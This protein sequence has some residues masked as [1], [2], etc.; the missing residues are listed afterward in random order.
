[1]STI[2]SDKVSTV[3]KKDIQELENK[4]GEF[5]L[6][7]IPE[8]KFKHFRLTRGVYGQ[9]Q[10]GV[11]LIRIKL[12]YG[13][14]TPK[15]LVKI[16]EV[17]EKYGSS[18]LHLT[19][20]QDVQI[21]YVKLSDSPKVWAELEE[22]GV[23]LREACGNTVRNVTASPD[24]GINPDEA[25][26]VTPYAHAFTQFFLRNPI[27]QDMGRKFKVAFSSSEK[28]TSFTYIHDL[29]FIPTIQNEGGIKKKGF[30]VYLGGGLG[31]QAIPAKKI[32]DFLPVESLIP[33]S[34]AVIRVFDRH[35][36]RA[37][38]NKA[39]LKFLIKKIGHEAFL[40]LVEKEKGAVKATGTIVSSGASQV[41]LPDVSAIEL[42]EPVDAVGFEKWKQTNVFEQKQTGFYGVY[43]RVQ[44]GDIPSEKAKKLAAIV[45]K[46]AGDDIR[47][48][49]NQGLLLKYVR[50]EV[51]AN[52]YNELTALDL[53]WA[54]FDSIHDI[55]ACP[56]SDTCNLAV[57]NSTGLSVVLEELLA[58]EYADLVYE[59]EIKIKISGCMNS[60]A[61][62]MSAQIGLHGSSIKNGA[63]IAP[64]MQIVLGGGIAP[65]GAGFIAEK[66]IKVPTKKVPDALR[67]I[68]NN[69]EDNKNDEE[70]FIDYVQRQGKRYFY[71]E[72][73]KHADLTQLAEQEYQDW[74]K[75]VNFIPEIGVG[76]C[77]GV[78][79][80]VIGNVI[81]ESQERLDR[82][83][84]AFDQA[85]YHDAI[86][87][88]YT[89]LV[90]GAKAL[91]LSEEHQCNTQVKL[92]ADFD[93]KFVATGRFELNQS[94]ESSVLELNEKEAGL[95]FALS[96]LHYTQSFLEKVKAFRKGQIEADSSQV[97]K[98]VVGDY[99]K[100]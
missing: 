61:Q 11:Q 30:I 64:A 71:A 9:R 22:E 14:I 59:S 84:E 58:K 70:N 68:L 34:E 24:A 31:A 33:F 35:G 53:H 54:G 60:C 96:Y 74:G 49:V 7:K 2:I 20:R 51:L 98:E 55:T 39:R 85:E 79:L 48:T 63:L 37:N 66:I 97:G 4:I 46:L 62:H 67:T 92:I 32:Y 25:F 18:N 75:E 89:S 23:T 45:K 47:V 26:D 56:G 69:F 17:S 93:E 44:L 100:A 21:H 76:E 83:K 16:A 72:L 77:A 5:Q 87:N 36:E 65:N 6:G 3:A 81:E 82:A 95:D 27:C 42:S 91:L 41:N 12:P 78:S 73:K 94:F 50:P 38:R 86:Y 90:I 52:L 15:Q 10:P 13:K 88:A 8:D 29:G 40:E 43:L 1:M 99:Y 19:T 80:D 57:T 28:D